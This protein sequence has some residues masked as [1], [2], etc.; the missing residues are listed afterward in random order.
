[1]A[2]GKTSSDSTPELAKKAT[3][4]LKVYVNQANV[5]ALPM[6]FVNPVNS[7]N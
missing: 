4:N 1:M 6:A 2:L 5:H 3:A 7:R